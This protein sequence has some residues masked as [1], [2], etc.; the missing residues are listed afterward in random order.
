M[1]ANGYSVECCGHMPIMA[2]MP[3]FNF[4][5]EPD[6]KVTVELD[7]QHLGLMFELVII[8]LE[9]C[10]PNVLHCGFISSLAYPIIYLARSLTLQP[11][12]ST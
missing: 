8:T 3:T 10:Y 4:S 11:S 1:A 5:P 9:I 12:L 7:M 2:D 6:R